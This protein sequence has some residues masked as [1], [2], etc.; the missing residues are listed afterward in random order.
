MCSGWRSRGRVALPCLWP[1][2]PV[3]T[4]L[5]V[6]AALRRPRLLAVALPALALAAV[7][8]AL[9]RPRLGLIAQSGAAFR[10]Y[11]VGGGASPVPIL[12]GGD[13][14]SEV[15]ALVV[16][17]RDDFAAAYNAPHAA[18]LEHVW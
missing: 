5:T 1:A 16:D 12:R 9:R 13:E 10:R 15:A 11:R 7:A 2:A 17:P 3:V 18:C 6:A 14:G 8:V 4:A